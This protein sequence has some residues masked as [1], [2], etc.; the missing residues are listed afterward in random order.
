MVQGGGGRI[1]LLG[2]PEGRLGGSEYLWTFHGHLAGTLAPLDLDLERAVQA[3]CLA[4]VEAGLRAAAHDCAEG[5]L[6]VA[7]AEAA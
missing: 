3:A 5:G 2:E 4:I 7:L 1:V 6:A